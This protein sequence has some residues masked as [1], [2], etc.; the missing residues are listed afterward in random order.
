MLSVL[1]YSMDCLPV[2]AQTAADRRCSIFTL[3]TV[4]QEN[5]VWTESVSLKL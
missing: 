3:E 2:F 4:R 5:A 1:R